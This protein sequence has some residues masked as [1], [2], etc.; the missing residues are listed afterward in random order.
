[1]AF[2]FRERDRSTC[3][4][5][6]VNAFLHFHAEVVS[7]PKFL[8]RHEFNAH[9]LCTVGN[10]LFELKV[11]GSFDGRIP[12]LPKG[13]GQ[14]CVRSPEG[15]HVEEEVEILGSPGFWECELNG[16]GASDNE[17]FRCGAER[18]EE[19]EQ[20]GLLGLGNHA[21]FQ[22]GSMALVKR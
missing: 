11:P 10:S 21:A 15:D 3:T 2:G 20:I 8:R 18:S 9:F 22:R 16:L 14:G 19:F 12:Q 17:I 7:P 1:M 6:G 13:G 5:A 4:G